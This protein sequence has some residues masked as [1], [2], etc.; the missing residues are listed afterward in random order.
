MLNRHEKFAVFN[1]T[2]LMVAVLLF[3][4]FLIVMGLPQAQGAFGLMGFI[5]LG[6]L[7]FLRKKRPSEI[8][9]DE[10]DKAI[11]LKANATGLYSSFVYFI[12]G[13]LVVYYSNPD[14]GVVSVDLIPLFVWVGWALYILA[15][16]I[17]ILVQ[18]RK[19]TNCGT[20]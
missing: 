9:D 15:Y 19:G 13:S 6:H 18:Y 5:G 12:I 2:I 16:S 3:F 20:C 14:A 1:L 4:L 7:L 10:R 11:K 8:V 17:T